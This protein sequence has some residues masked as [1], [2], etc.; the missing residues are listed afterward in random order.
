MRSVFFTILFAL[1]LSSAN[2]QD[3]I[4][5]SLGEWPPFTGKTL[6]GCG[7][8]ATLVRD[9]FATEGVAVAFVHAPWKRAFFEAETG[10]I[11]GTILWRKTPD[12]Q[13][14]FL[15]SDPVLSV[16][17]V[18][19]HQKKMPFDWNDLTDLPPYTFA[20]VAG[21]KMHD[22][23]DAAAETGRLNVSYAISQ[24]NCFRRLLADRIQVVVLDKTSGYATLRQ[25]F[26]EKKYRRITHH[27]I[28]LAKV[29]MHL[30]LSRKREKNNRILLKK[31][32]RGLARIQEAPPAPS[33]LP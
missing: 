13:Q 33:P 14:N 12:R 32:N 19:F 30:L 7:S 25:N 15:I 4:L 31:F 20:T 26:S 22:G 21:F 6:K 10:R 17:I 23:F 18:F 8:A 16:D 1:L 5:I 9:A 28:P 2:A 3:A 27:P 29:E 24:E 11:D